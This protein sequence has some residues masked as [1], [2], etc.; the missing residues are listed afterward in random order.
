MVKELSSTSLSASAPGDLSNFKTALAAAKAVNLK[1][2]ECQGGR[3]Y[4]IIP[5]GFKAQETTDPDGLDAYV[6]ATRVFDD[7]AS[8]IAYC[9]VYRE[10]GAV[11]LADLD[12]DC[13]KALLD[14]HEGDPSGRTSGDN[15]I[16]CEVAPNKHSATLQLRP[17]EEWKAWNAFENAG[18][19]E[20]AEFARFLEENANDVIEPEP[21]RLIEI[22]RDLE[23]TSDAAFRSAV[24]LRSGNRTF[25]Y[26][27]KDNV[28]GDI[29][30]PKKI[31]IDIPFWFGAEQMRLEAMFRYRAGG[32]GMKL[33]ID[34]HRVE[35]Q[36]QAAFKL[37]ATKVAEETGI[38]VFFGRSS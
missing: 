12:R 7:A 19:Y 31:A 10:A 6:K 38:P 18:F 13:V 27:T 14:Y 30:I 33:A 25:H 1:P 23:I 16:V 5:E 32:N 3:E 36:R 15:G 35:Y 8:L 37:I 2:V 29:V 11:I 17:S 22:A 28:K 9:N 26:E 4:L 34:W 20:Q 21:N 24:D